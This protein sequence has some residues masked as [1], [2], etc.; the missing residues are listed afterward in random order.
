MIEEIHI[1]DLGVITD[2][3][4]PLG[5][6]LTILSGETGAGKTM[7]VTALG[8]LLG[9]RADAGAV[10]T[11]AEKAV[12]EAVVTV[13]ADHA[14]VGL[15]EDAGGDVDREEDS[16]T[17]QLSRT[18]AATGRSRAHVGGRSA[19]VARLGEL[20]ETLVAVH[21]QSDQL[22]LTS[23]AAQRRA[24]DT[25][26]AERGASPSRSGRSK[27]AAAEGSGES[28]GALLAS[29]RSALADFEAVEA[30]LVEIREKGRERALEAQ[31]LRAALEEIDAVEPVPGEDEA[32]DAESQ[33]LTSLESLRAASLTAHAAL[34]GGDED[35]EA[36]ASILLVDRAL[37]ALDQEADA[38]PELAQLAQRVR[39]LSVLTNDVA[40]DLSAYST[41]LDE[42]G[43]A[44]L[45]EVEARRAALRGL[46]K[47]YGADIAE[48]LAFAETARTRLD[49]L[50]D[51]PRREEELAARRAELLETLEA[52]AGELT[53][54]RR[55]AAEHL[56]AEVGAELKALAMPNAALIVSVE[57][58]GRFDRWGRDTVELLLRAHADASPRP[59]GKGASGGELSRLMLALEVV[60]AAVDPVPTFV[61]DEVDS[62]VGGKAAL[63]I[64]RRL[65]M[66]AQNVQVLVVTHLPQVA[67]FADEHVLVT[68][69]SDSTVSDVTVLS[70]EQRVIE[71]A[72]MLAGHEDSQAAQE[73]ARELLRDAAS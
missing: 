57:P 19:P 64:G 15:V 53:A 36:P 59:L 52:R 50:G 24:L 10:R 13:P 70:H 11:G 5:P 18:V 54:R 67:A 63:E 40:A 22:R 69:S 45:A 8:M 56:A 42:D 4:L 65:K 7:V 34:S 61:F 21:G 73:H 17:V 39:E 66:L 31:S 51:D 16:A 43:P 14:A 28:F 29:Y 6:G 25:F 20:G 44:R 71:L 68:K 26:A 60:L 72:R 33:K 38:D 55:S 58:S 32:L 23:A 35:P 27:K 12:A 1:R 46:T 41:G 2:A 9:R 47:T 3:V 49:S 62:G 37:S 48:V 30:E